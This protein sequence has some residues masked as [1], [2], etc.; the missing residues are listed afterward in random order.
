MLKEKCQNFD[1]I[2]LNNNKIEDI[3]LWKDGLHLNDQGKIILA[4]NFIDY[5]NYFLDKNFYYLNRP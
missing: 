1:F 2:Y 5:I 4:R 3:H